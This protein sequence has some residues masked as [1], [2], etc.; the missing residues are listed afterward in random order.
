[1]RLCQLQLITGRAGFWCVFVCFVWF[2]VFVVCF[3]VLQ[4]TAQWIMYRSNAGLFCMHIV[5]MT[6]VATALIR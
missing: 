5:V 6:D 1:M 2:W 3:F 4:V